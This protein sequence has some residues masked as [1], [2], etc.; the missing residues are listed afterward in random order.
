MTVCVFKQTYRC[1]ASSE[2]ADSCM[3]AEEGSPAADI[4]DV[5][6]LAGRMLL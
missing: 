5:A 3:Q 1:L 2:T 6:P 4:I